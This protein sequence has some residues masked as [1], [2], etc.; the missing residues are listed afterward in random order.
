MLKIQVII[1][2]MACD[3]SLIC[4]FLFG[5]IGTNLPMETV[6]IEL[7][8]WMVKGILTYRK[9]HTMESTMFTPW[10]KKVTP[11]PSLRCKIKAYQDGKRSE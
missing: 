11:F 4:D 8:A 9:D 2:G 6:D 5:S 10:S 7:T 1:T 3:I